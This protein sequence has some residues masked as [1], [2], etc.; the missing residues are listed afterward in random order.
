MKYLEAEDRADVFV[1]HDFDEHV[2]DLGEV[3]LNYSTVGD[4]ALPPLVLVPGQ[5]NSWWA[6]EKAMP[7]LTEAFQVFAV[8]LRGQGRSTWTP[9]RYT[10]DNFGNDLVRF[11]DLVV[12][13][14]AIV[15]GHSSGGVVSAWLAA[16]AKPGQV[17]ATV[18]EDAPIFASET[19]PACGPSIR[20]GAGPIFG[21]WNKWL[22]DQWSIGDVDGMQKAL[23]RELP[24]AL[25]AWLS[26]IAPPRQPAASGV[27]Q[28]L[29][30]YDPEWGRAFLSGSVAASCDHENLVSHVKV[31]V[32][33]THHS[34]QED[35][36][37]GSLMG[38]ISDTQV[39]RVEELVTAAGQ[40]FTYRSF[41]EMPHSMHEHDPRL[42]ADTVLG[43]AEGLG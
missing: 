4:P 7:L 27:P 41:P 30:E 24:P 9:G 32:L 29:R 8:D 34:R 6:Y 10:I 40:E 39:R 20:Q 16:F 23:P 17:R 36:S 33:F 25:L 19:E 35:P 13:R 21:L 18:W 37:T 42:F 38:A 26:R 15:S 11:L 28:N 14:P 22:G 5:C 12:G 3:R 31:P 1:L 43:W 2:V